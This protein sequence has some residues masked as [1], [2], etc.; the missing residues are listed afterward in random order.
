MYTDLISNDLVP[1]RASLVAPGQN[2]KK[3][4]S[5]SALRITDITWPQIDDIRG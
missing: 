4:L 2:F 1:F 3:S 5:E